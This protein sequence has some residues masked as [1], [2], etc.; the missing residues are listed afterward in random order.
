[1]VSPCWAQPPATVLASL[2][3]RK[4]M[5]R[6]TFAEVSTCCR[7]AETETSVEPQDAAEDFQRAGDT[8]TTGCFLWLRHPDNE[9]GA[10]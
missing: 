2:W 10:P 7:R 3:D 8:I 6:S 4:D 9:F 1:V 5:A